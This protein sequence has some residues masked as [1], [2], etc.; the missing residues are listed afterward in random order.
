MAFTAVRSSQSTKNTK[1]KNKANVLEI[2]KLY[3]MK[4]L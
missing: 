2:N 3:A 4:T 1:K